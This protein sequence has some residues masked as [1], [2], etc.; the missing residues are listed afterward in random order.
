M[1][2]FLT[3]LALLT[4]SLAALASPEP[5]D[6]TVQRDVTSQTMI[7]R[8]TVALSQATAF[9][10]VDAHGTAVYTDSVRAGDYINKRFPLAALPGH[11]YAIEIT[12]GAGRT[13]LPFRPRARG[14]IA[15]LTEA[16]HDVYPHID[17]RAERTLV[18]DCDNATG[19]RVD[20]RI[21][22][23]AGHTVF[24]DSVTGVTAVQRAYRLDRL[25]AGEYQVIVSGR[26]VADH[27]MA[28]ALH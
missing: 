14:R 18:V 17:L 15:L 19:R 2:L 13:V 9:R 5:Q 24:T 6:V 23:Q 10:I 22:N 20:I 7:V 28:I 27:S 16:K 25:N 21:K 12:D 26:D 4:A 3:L 11:R 1:K 8:S